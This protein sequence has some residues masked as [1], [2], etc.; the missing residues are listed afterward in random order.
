M[1]PLLLLITEKS[2][3]LIMQKLKIFK[4]IFQCLIGKKKLKMKIQIKLIGY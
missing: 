3:I 2:G 1:Y 4:K